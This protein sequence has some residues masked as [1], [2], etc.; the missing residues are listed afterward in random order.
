MESHLNSYNASKNRS[1]GR[2]ALVASAA[3][4]AAAF[5]IAPA[6]AHATTANSI[7]VP[8]VPDGIG[9]DTTK[10]QVFLVGHAFGTQNYMCLPAANGGVAFKLFTPEATLLND[11]QKQLI[12]HFFSPNPKEPNTDPTLAAIGKIR[13]TW[14]YRDG[15]SVWATTLAPT[16]ISTDQQFVADGAVAWLRLT[17][18]GGQIGPDGGDTLA[19]VSFVQRLNTAGGLAP[20]T[21]CATTADIGHEAFVPYTADYFFYR[22]IDGATP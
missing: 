1:A 14:Q 20:K 19:N 12:T 11:D 16:D 6:T 13:A 8:A 7:V 3:V 5:L 2:T 4:V 9:V 15:S 21:G 10:N 17:G 22:A 18:V